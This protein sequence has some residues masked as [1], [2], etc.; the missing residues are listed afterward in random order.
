LK[1]PQTE[2]TAKKTGNKAIKEVIS[3]IAEIAGLLW[4]KGWA[5]RNAGNIS[6]NI[7]SLL[8]EAE[9]MQIRDLPLVRK[10]IIQPLPSGG[11][12]PFSRRSSSDGG[13]QSLAGQ[14]FIFTG[15]GT[16]MRD[17]CKNPMDNLCFVR[18]NDNGDGYY[19]F[20]WQPGNSIRQPTSELPT[21]LVIHDYLLRSKPEIK[22]VVHTHAHELVALSH[23]TR[24]QSSKAINKLL[25]SMHPET[26]LFVPQGV[27]IVPYSLPG[28]EKI[29]RTTLR[30]LKKHSVIIWEKHGIMATG[31]S[32]TE[33]FDSIDILAKS[34]RIFF[35]CRSAGFDPE[36]LSS[37]ELNEI[38]KNHLKE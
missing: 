10:V 14:I 5:E 21:H 23:I 38:R 1:K 9:F 28:T 8:S 2:V 15:V 37:K 25:W 3:E 16:R 34:A 6:V 24:F 7:T 35:T 19:I 26:L 32:V 33:A 31:K 36:G 13:I 22:A 17:V 4:E 29:A 30:E 20:P 27:G 18:I 12:F 11:F